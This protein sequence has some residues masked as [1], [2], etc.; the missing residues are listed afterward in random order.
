MIMSW[1]W[2]AFCITGPQSVMDSL[3]KG[4]VRHPPQ[5]ARFIRPT[6]GTPGSCRP[7][8]S[9]MLAPWTLL[10]GTVLYS[11]ERL[12]KID[13]FSVKEMPSGAIIQ[14]ITSS[15]PSWCGERSIDTKI[16]FIFNRKDNLSQINQRHTL[17]TN[18]SHFGNLVE[19]FNW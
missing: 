13:I 4:P 17:P 18:M 9:P 16:G 12:D 2:K 19:S 3:H 10:S 8:M 11:M 1:H 5:I 15:Q 6:W 7:Q 14:G